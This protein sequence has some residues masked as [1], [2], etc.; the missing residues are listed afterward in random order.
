MT[1]IKGSKNKTI[2]NVF[3]AAT[4]LMAELGEYLKQRIKGQMYAIYCVL[5]TLFESF[6]IK[7]VGYK[8][9]KASFLLTGLPGVG[10]TQLVEELAK[11]LNLP[12][13]RFNMSSYS[14]K[15]EAVFNFKGNNESY[16]AART[17]DVTKFVEENPN[18]ILLF[19]EIDKAHKNVRN[20]YYQILEGGEL[21]DSYM[22]KKVSFKNTIIFMTTNVGADLFQDLDRYNYATLPDL[23]IM[24]ALE[25]EKNPNTNETYFSPAL[26]S[27]FAKGKIIPFNRLNGQLLCEM[28]KTKAEEMFSR[29]YELYPDIQLKCDAQSLAK[30]LIFSKGGQTDARNLTGAVDHFFGKHLFDIMQK[31]E[32]NRQ[33]FDKI[34]C[35]E[36]TFDCLDGEEN[37]KKMFQLDETYKVA[38]YCSEEEREAFAKC[39][40]LDFHFV[41]M[42]DKVTS[43][44][45]DCAIVSADTAKN[46]TSLQYFRKIKQQDD[47][48]V[49]VFSLNE[50]TDLIDLKTYYC[51]GADSTYILK[52][53]RTF[54][55]WLDDMAISVQLA[56]I[57]SFLSRANLLLQYDTVYSY[58]VD[59]KR[60]VLKVKT[61][62]YRLERALYVEDES[63]FV[64][65]HEIPNVKF[66]DIKGL[67]STLAE[68]KDAIKFVKN[69]KEYTRAG[70]KIPKGFLFYGPSGTGKTLLAKA[71]AAESG[72]PII[73]RNA[74]EYLRPL[75]GE[76]EETLKKDFA[77]AR[78][79]A[80][81]VLFIDEIDGIAKKRGRTNST[82][83][84]E[85]I[86]NTLFTEMDG[87]I[88]DE[89]KPVFVIAATNFEPNGT[90]N[91]L[92]EAFVRRFD[93]SFNIQLPNAK[94]RMKILQYYLEKYAIHIPETKM[95]NFVERSTGKSPAELEK[96][97]NYAVRKAIG[98]S[99]ETEDLEEALEFISHGEQ[100]QWDMDTVRKTSYHEAGHC[101]IA[102]LTG[103]TP[104]YVTNI[105]R[106]SH[107]G[108]MQFES[109][110]D[111]Q[112]YS[113][114]ELLDKICV[115]FAGRVAEQ[116]IYKEE[117]I[118][119]GSQADLKQ[120]RA[121]AQSLVDG[122]GMDMDLLLGMDDVKSETTKRLFDRKINTILKE[123]YTRAR[124]LIAQN[125]QALEILTKELIQENGLDS[126]QIDAILNPLI[127]TRYQSGS[128]HEEVAV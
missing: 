40:W 71:I 25:A 32:E 50:N 35:I 23:K 128:T 16:K 5:E 70:I 42:K 95:T 8:G 45:Y 122:Y 49:H 27:R 20:L 63:V 123:Q 86:L 29:F 88:H 73:Q 83:A 7:D 26:V 85:T 77:R 101:L 74:A 46:E 87:F 84:S 37:V 104:A 21:E 111:K 113:R 52:D 56:K 48:P 36:F 33:E 112:N 64:S 81:A 69:H 68:V 66:E 114:R 19:D 127:K 24:R 11:Y 61:F 10:K 79:Y 108:Y 51:E 76:G 58:D 34:S 100:K 1:V 89:K 75:V 28:A 67:D 6:T 98:R 17:G 65:D 103:N 105:S 117:G 90:A 43:L 15:E 126:R 12:Y 18:A 55:S 118:T 110:E 107:G 119:T 38:V 13:A 57:S 59:E 116:L 54:L 9:P 97:V 124:E 102:W 99:V 94:G 31:Y 115:C 53:E 96:I 106:G 121:L 78:R 72:M 14:D 80:P 62:N 93:T 82:A 120:A 39:R 92:D 125:R 2:R 44:D 91:G 109:E 22:R 47:L 3:P 4:K 41:S 60:A 30:T